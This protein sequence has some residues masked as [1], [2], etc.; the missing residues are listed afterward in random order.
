MKKKKFIIGGFVIF[1]VIGYLGYTGF[2]GSA[3]YY[4]TVSEFMASKAAANGETVRVNGEVVPGSVEQ[5]AGGQTIKF[6]IVDEKASLNVVYTGVV[7]DTFK[8]GNEAVVEG[9]LDSAGMFKADTLMPKCASK[10]ASK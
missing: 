3:S 8:A 2:M 4:Y 1:A 10:Y 6:A 7:P 5:E 9:H